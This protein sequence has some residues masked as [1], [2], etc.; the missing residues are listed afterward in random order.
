ML[1]YLNDQV[2]VHQGIFS[3]LTS[4]TFYL[5]FKLFQFSDLPPEASFVESSLSRIIKEIKQNIMFY[6]RAS[7]QWNQFSIFPEPAYNIFNA[8][9]FSWLEVK[10]GNTR[11]DKKT[12]DKLLDVEYLCQTYNFPCR[13][14]VIIGKILS[15]SRANLSL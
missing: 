1:L 2:Q 14:F 8:L 12:E 5:T 9:R 10:K 15:S 6:F 7:L 13:S 4:K 3:R 11:N